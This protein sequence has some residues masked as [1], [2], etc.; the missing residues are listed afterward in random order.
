MLGERHTFLQAQRRPFTIALMELKDRLK[1][2]RKDAGLTQVELAERAG[3]KQASVSEIERG[4]TRTSGYLVKMAQV[5]GVDPLWLAEGVVPQEPSTKSTPEPNAELLGDLVV[6]EPGD[7]LEAD[8]VEVP[9]YAEV[10]LSGGDGMTEV[11]EVAGRNLRFSRETLRAAG[12]DKGCAAVARVK[13]RSMER[14]ILDGAAVG[15]DMS[16]TSII[17]GEIYAFNHGGLLRTKYLYRMPGGSVRI[18]SE[19]S[20]EYPDEILS[21]ERWRDEV[22]M[23]G[24]VFWWSTVRRSPRRR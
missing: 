23:L 21:A 16:D 13:G 12:V 5:C 2:A 20:A 9:Y 8:D 22:Q 14:L 3:I 24:R 6:W 10:E 4:L 19:N 18:S 15:F 11:V 17:D 1:K 7:P